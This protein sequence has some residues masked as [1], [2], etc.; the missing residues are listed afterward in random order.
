M[1]YCRVSGS[2]PRE[3]FSC[4]S[5]KIKKPTCKD[6]IVGLHEQVE[7]TCYATEA[8]YNMILYPFGQASGHASN[9]YGSPRCQIFMW[10][11]DNSLILWSFSLSFQQHLTSMTSRVYF[12]PRQQKK[13][14]HH[15]ILLYFS[16]LLTVYMV[17]NSG[18]IT[19]PGK[20][21]K[22]KQAWS[23]QVNSI[24]IKC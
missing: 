6:P 18:W 9:F 7:K 5:L 4:V 3:V 12:R 8:F 16:C 21:R 22:Y 17:G 20:Q 2:T 23:L 11:R 13:T 10:L 19:N 14:P 1:H 24:L 15:R